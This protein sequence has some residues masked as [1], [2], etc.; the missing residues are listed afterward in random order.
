ML[1]TTGPTGVGKTLTAEVLAK[2]AH[3]PL[4][5]A[6]ISEIGTKPK[7]AEKGMKHLFELAQAWNAILLM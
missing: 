6:S 5:K 1:I 4:Y 7:E 2:V 3:M